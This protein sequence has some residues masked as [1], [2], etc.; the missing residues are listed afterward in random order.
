MTASL[1]AV[2]LY[3][4]E[5]PRAGDGPDREQQRPLW[6]ELG[7]SPLSSHPHFPPLGR[8]AGSGCSHTLGRIVAQSFLSLH[9]RQ[10]SQETLRPT[11]HHVPPGWFFVR[12]T[13]SRAEVGHSSCSLYLLRGEKTGPAKVGEGCRGWQVCTPV[14]LS[15]PE[16]QEG[17]SPG[18][19][20]LG[21][22][23]WWLQAAG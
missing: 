11:K 9:Q 4:V 16:A 17:G 21:A 2:S 8:G 15:F 19:A 20:R 3:W 14:L 18:R 13:D 5:P 23:E 10:K 7:N 22:G 6:L 12:K 1:C